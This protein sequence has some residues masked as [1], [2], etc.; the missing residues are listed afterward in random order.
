MNLITSC[1]YFAYTIWLIDTDSWAA[2]WLVDTILTVCCIWCY[3]IHVKQKQLKDKY[4]KAFIRNFLFKKYSKV[5]SAN[6]LMEFNFSSI[7]NTFQ[8]PN[9]LW[10]RMFHTGQCG[11]IHPSWIKSQESINKNVFVV[12]DNNKWLCDLRHTSFFG[13]VQRQIFIIQRARNRQKTLD[14]CWKGTSLKWEIPKHSSS[15]DLIHIQ[16]INT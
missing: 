5:D 13:F 11:I 1:Y 3:I 9:I 15:W 2:D 8:L 7:S 4:R 12:K 6:H 16:F 14:Y 10:K